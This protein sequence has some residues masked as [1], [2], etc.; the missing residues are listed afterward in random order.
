MILDVPIN[1]E[2]LLLRNLD[3]KDVGQHYLDWMSDPEVVRYLEVRFSVPRTI[4]ELAK[5]VANKNES[6]NELLLGIILRD[7]QRHIGNIKL[8]PIC[9]NHNRADL[10]FIIGDRTAWGK[11]YATEAILATTRFALDEL[12]LAKVSAGC[13]A[14]N[15]GSARALE[16]AGFQQEGILHSHCVVDGERED[17]LLFGISAQSGV[18]R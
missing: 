16:K 18:A 15:Q 17:V 1:T 13:Y 6:D 8:G 7:S 11:G 9:W 10:G 2:R 4:A 14:C 3:A 12:K 5:F